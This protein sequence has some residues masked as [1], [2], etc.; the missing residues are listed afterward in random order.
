MA[1][2]LLAAPSQSVSAPSLS[3]VLMIDPHITNYTA[4][5]CPSSH[6][7]TPTFINILLVSLGAAHFIPPSEKKVC[8][9]CCCYSRVPIFLVTK[10][11]FVL[12]SDTSGKT[13]I[14]GSLSPRLPW[15]QS[16]FPDD[17]IQSVLSLAASPDS[18]RRRDIN[19]SDVLPYRLQAA[20]SKRCGLERRNKNTHTHTH[21]HTHTDGLLLIW[22]HFH[23]LPALL[24]GACHNALPATWAT[25]QKVHGQELE[26]DAE[27]PDWGALGVNV[28]TSPARREVSYRLLEGSRPVPSLSPDQ[29][30]CLER[31]IVIQR[32]T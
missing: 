6:S 1:I 7:S 23:T 27:G 18:Q 24:R 10:T 17:W 31:Q 32:H 5:R 11:R 16:H 2:M 25:C 14:G 3:V 8:C 20:A 13:N 9:C 21:T 28:S 15:L 4:Q 30:L 29:R 26:C 22:I 12:G 19:D